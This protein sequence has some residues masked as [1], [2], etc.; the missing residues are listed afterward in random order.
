MHLEAIG[1]TKS[2]SHHHCH[3]VSQ[4]EAGGGYTAIQPQQRRTEQRE[5]GANGDTVGYVDVMSL[6]EI[7]TAYLSQHFA[8]RTLA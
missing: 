1:A 6:C 8:P 3:S 5:E 2:V 4:G 7:H